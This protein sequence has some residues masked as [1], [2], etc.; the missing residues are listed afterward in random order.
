M[1]R[2]L[3]SRSRSSAKATIVH[4]ALWLALTACLAV[5]T[6][7]CD[8]A[9]N[10]TVSSTADGGGGSLR[11][12]IARANVSRSAVIIRIPS[13]TYELTRCGADDDNRA[14]DL[15]VTASKPV[16]L[17]ATGADVVIRQTCAGERVLDALADGLLILK[18]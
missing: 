5:V 15:D 11:A 13:G 4:G 18:A 6:T 1:L 16:T 14:G 17:E 10:I 2:S 8:R 3:A 7:S 12:A 9:K